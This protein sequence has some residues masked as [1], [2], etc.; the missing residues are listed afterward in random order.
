MAPDI[1]VP[2]LV[3]DACAGVVANTEPVVAAGLDIPAAVTPEEIEGEA[4]ILA[5][6]G[7]DATP[8]AA[9]AGALAEAGLLAE[10]AT[11]LG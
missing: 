9:P 5:L 8:D 4:A 2:E 11:P 6:V 3:G 1:D 10:P 7:P